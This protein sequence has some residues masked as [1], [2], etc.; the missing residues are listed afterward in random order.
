M[1]F[2]SIAASCKPER[3]KGKFLDDATISAVTS[4]SFN[5][6]LGEASQFKEKDLKKRQLSINWIV[7]YDSEFLLVRLHKKLTEKCCR[8][9]F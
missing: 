2:A 8:L 5:V 6:Y 9:L 1:F 4:N 7:Y 3:F